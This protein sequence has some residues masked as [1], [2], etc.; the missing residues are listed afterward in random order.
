MH[1][2]GNAGVADAMKLI[3]KNL[4]SL[5]LYILK[6]AYIL[7]CFSIQIVDVEIVDLL[8]CVCSF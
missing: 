4:K 6:L 1:S 2:I 3:S 7:W 8:L 5:P